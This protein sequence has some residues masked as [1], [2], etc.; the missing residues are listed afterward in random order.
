MKRAEVKEAYRW[1]L[2]DIFPDDGAWE[3][4]L[5]EAEGEIGSIDF[6]ETF[7]MTGVST[8][9]SMQTCYLFQGQRIFDVP[10][11]L[12]AQWR[13]DKGRV[14]IAWEAPEE[15]PII[16]PYHFVLSRQ[17]EGEDFFRAYRSINSDQTSFEDKRLKPGES[18][19]YRL[20]ILFEDGRRTTP[21]NEVK[22]TVPKKKE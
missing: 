18:T 10:I 20:E 2:E 21:S 12:D 8:G 15:L 9:L 19:V 6:R 1:R 14:Y 4:E 13:E 5:K 11:K 16:A 17:L 3:E 7:N 22:V